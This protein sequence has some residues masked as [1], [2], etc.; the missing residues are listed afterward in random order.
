MT[1]EFPQD[2][3]SI[4]TTFV[5]EPPSCLEFR[6]AESDNFIV[7]T[8]LLSETKDDSGNIHQKKTGSVQ[9]WSLNRDVFSL[10]LVQKIPL[11]YAVFDLHFHPTN[12]DLF[13]I[14]T[15][16]GAISLF[17]LLPSEDDDGSSTP[18]IKQLW[19]LPVHDDPS[20]SALFLAW[21]SP[22]WFL[23][24]REGFAVT[25]SDGSTAVFGT[26]RGKGITELGDVSKFGSF[27]ARE[28]IEVWFVALHG[29]TGKESDTLGTK[30]VPYLFTGNDFGSLRI[31][32]FDSSLPHASHADDEDEGEEEA[33]KVLP[34][35][36]LDQDDRGRHH[37]A[38]VTSI[39]PLVVKNYEDT[40]ILLTGSYDEYL[41]VYNGTMK[42]KVLSEVCLGGGVWRLQVFRKEEGQDESRF[43]VLASCMHA[44]TRIV[45]V[46]FR[47]DKEGG[48]WELVVLAK[49]TEHESMNYASDSWKGNTKGDLACV[50][51]SFYDRR[52]CFWRMEL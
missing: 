47:V 40:P 28:P 21:A 42:G 5:D 31:L 32:R 44:G 18:G 3:K 51:S 10:S 41:R 14:A 15:S 7:G 6:D 36:V 16:T 49:F 11:P 30:K 12:R 23:D 19:T 35:V 9:L 38:G 27:E 26:E 46:T 2:L 45:K 29:Y 50:S 52:L 25:F 33:K 1:A 13:A 48:K 43:W 39:L 4:T 34:E 8:Y 24:N 20:I 22:D 17:Q 37:S